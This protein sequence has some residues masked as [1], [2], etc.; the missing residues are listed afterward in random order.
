MRL[1]LAHDNHVTSLSPRVLVSLAMKL[2]LVFVRSALVDF[3]LD[4]FLLLDDLLTIASLALILFVD[5]FS[6]ATA[7]VAR[8]RRLG[9]HSRS[10]LRHLHDHASS[11]AGWTGLH[12]SFL[13]S[14]AFT[15]GT[16]SLSVDCNFG[17]L[18][19]VDLLQSEL[20]GMHDRLALLWLLRTALSAHAAS[21]HLRE[22][23][24]HTAASASILQTLFAV[25]VVDVSLLLV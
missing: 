9:V 24:V 12:C 16:N 18:S 4:Y 23:V 6:F 1:L 13:A 25:L 14:F 3:D 5:D 10:E 19:I 2:V 20:H 8:P 17:R 7:L 21:K 15:L 22:D 11:L